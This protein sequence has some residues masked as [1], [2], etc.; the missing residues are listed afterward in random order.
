LMRISDST[1]KRM[2]EVR[3]VKK[4]AVS[5]VDLTQMIPLVDQ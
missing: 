2:G 3:P 4:E 1:A 5:E